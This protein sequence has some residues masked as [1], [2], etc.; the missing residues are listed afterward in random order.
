MTHLQGCVKYKSWRGVNLQYG[1]FADSVAANIPGCTAPDTRLF[2][3]ADFVEN[4][5]QS[6]E[7]WLVVMRPEFAAALE[8]AGWV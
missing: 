4:K 3:L 7:H 8:D 2:L 1:L 5:T 6:N